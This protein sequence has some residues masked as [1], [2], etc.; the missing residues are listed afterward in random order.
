MA[1]VL[2]TTQPSYNKN[3]VLQDVPGY[4]GR[5]QQYGELSQYYYYWAWYS[6]LSSTSARIYVRYCVYNTGSESVGYSGTMYCS[7]DGS[8]KHQ[9]TSYSAS[10]KSITGLYGSLYW[11]V[12]WNTS[13]G[14]WENKQIKIWF[15]GNMQSTNPYQLT[16][17]I[18]LPD[19]DPIPSIVSRS[20]AI[21]ANGFHNLAVASISTIRYTATVSY[22]RSAVLTV[23]GAG[24]T[25]TYNLTVTKASSETITQDFIA[26]PST[27]NY[28]LTMT[29][30]VSNDTGTYTGNLKDLTRSIN[31]YSLPTYANTTYTTRCRSDGTADSQGEY[32]RLYLTWTIAPVDTSNPNTLQTCT[33]KLNNTTISATS[34]SIANGYLDFIF[35]LAVNVQGN[36]EVY[37]VDQIYHNTITSLVVPKSIMPLSLYQSGDSVGVAIG[38]MA[39]D[40]GFWC[41]EEF[42][43]K[44]SGGTNV[45]HIS[46]NS[47]GQLVVTR[48]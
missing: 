44:E 46:V 27:Q 11:D 14:K 32:G 26:P 15:T 35:P 19:I 28:T 13:T 18:S 5:A 37:F 47:S 41:Y 6:K 42:Y 34:G 2:Q 16:N 38:R 9:N 10:A 23:T 39:T 36:M 17:T 43:L 30:T 29:L 12:N 1:V 40:S 4:I 31:G 3:T 20:S 24:I 48:V 45:Y 7:I 22:A 21:Q 33:V 8:E 25:N